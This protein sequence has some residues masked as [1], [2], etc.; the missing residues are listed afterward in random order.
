MK[1]I[2]IIGAGEGLSYGVAEKF[3]SEGYTIGLISRNLGKLESLKQKLNQKGI[4]CHVEAANAYNPNEL[5]NAIQKL[6]VNMGT[7]EVLHYN[8]AALKMQDLLKETSE[9]LTEDFKI[10]VAN[11][12]H[13]V[14]V[15][16]NDLITNQGSVLFT[17]GYFA[18]EPNSQFGSLSIGKAGLRNLSHQLHDEL[19]KDQVFVATLVINGY[20]QD[21]SATHSPRILAEKFWHLFKSRKEK[22]EIY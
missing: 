15:L 6:K 19:K 8:A 18:I 16:M 17:G 12:L 20:I 13:C 1:T 2:I 4:Q 7:V 21:A 14:K 5:E 3:G 22:E 10:S 11:A 9:S